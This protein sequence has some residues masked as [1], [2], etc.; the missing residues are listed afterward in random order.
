MISDYKAK[1]DKLVLQREVAEK[2][3]Q[4]EMVSVARSEG[5]LDDVEEGQRITQG[6]AQAVQQQVHDRIAGVVSR[7]LEAVFDDPYEFQI[8]F[9]QKRGRTEARLAFVR[10]GMELDPMT[11][12][13]G[14]VIDVAAFALR[15]ACLMLIRPRV[16]HLVVC[17]EP[18]RFVSVEYRP[19]M[20]EMLE[21]LAEDMEIQFVMVTHMED[22]KM[23][24]VVEI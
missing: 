13:G 21:G 3:Y 17:D 8:L 14:G 1:I 18:F 11:A 22:L 20:R 16:R 5:H 15:L 19:R 9:E 7:C 2:T 12:S 24:T 10:E 23:G 6:V 4:R